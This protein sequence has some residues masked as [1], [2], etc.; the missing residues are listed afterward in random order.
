MERVEIQDVKML[1]IAWFDVSSTR[2]MPLLYW[3][4]MGMVRASIVTNSVQISFMILYIMHWEAHVTV[5]TTDLTC[6][7]SGVYRLVYRFH[8]SLGKM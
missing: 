3:I 1:F 5:H 7:C 6:H 2:P 8:T 4:G